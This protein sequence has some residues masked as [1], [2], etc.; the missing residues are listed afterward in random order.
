MAAAYFQLGELTDKIGDKKEALAVHRQGLALRR[1]LAAAEG[2]DLE[3]RLDVARSLSQVGGLLTA[4]GDYAGAL[5]ACGEQRDPAERLEV[6]H[7]TDSVRSSL[8][9]SHHN[10][11]RVLSYTRKSEQPI[12]SYRKAL[13][14]RQE[15][16]DANPAVTEFEVD[17]AKTYHNLGGLL[18]ETGKPEE[19]LTALRKALAIWQKLADANPPGAEFQERLAQSHIPIGNL[20]SRTGK[21]KV[22]LEAERKALALYQ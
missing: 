19:A 4:T 21:P 8:A 3:T 6:E 10:I 9:N 5:A 2:A 11:A 17:L 1:E 15:L 12:V 14:I 20:L 18:R 7:A 16:V 13:A 22:A